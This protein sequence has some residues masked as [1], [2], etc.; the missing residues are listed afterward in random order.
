MLSILATS[1]HLGLVVWLRE[2]LFIPGHLGRWA[3]RRVVQLG[4]IVR[5]LQHHRAVAEFLNET[6]L[7]LNGGI[8]Y[9][10]DLV[11]LEA[12]P[13]LVASGVDEVDNIQG[14]DEIDESIA[15]VTVIGEIDSE[16]HE[17]VLA[18][19]RLIN[20]IL[21]H[22]LVDLVWDV[23]KHD[24]GADVSTLTNLVDVD[25]VMVGSRW[26]EVSTI[27]AQSILTTIL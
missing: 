11:A 19:A 18:P 4:S 24:S 26:T 8:R 7:A 25:V 20:Y 21:Q 9:L 22:G 6:V 14:V 1:L 16:I 23:S 2:W 17:I 12:V 3:I 15:N 10:G 5:C 13:A 27:H